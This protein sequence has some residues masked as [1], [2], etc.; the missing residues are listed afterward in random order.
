MNYEKEFKTHRS[1]YVVFLQKVCTKKLLQEHPDSN[2]IATSCREE[3]EWFS[4]IPYLS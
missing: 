1:R 2:I 4:A 3:I